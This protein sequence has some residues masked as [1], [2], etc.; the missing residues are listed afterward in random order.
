M[1]SPLGEGP[2]EVITSMHN[3]GPLSPS[4]KG[5]EAIHSGDCTLG[6]ESSQTFRGQPDMG[7]ELALIPKDPAQPPVRVGA[8]ESLVTKRVLTQVQLTEAPSPRALPA[9]TS[10]GA[11][12]PWN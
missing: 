8:C 9:V 1:A 12:D 11:G 5:P 2:H 10:T 7:P 4:P 6:T 3:D